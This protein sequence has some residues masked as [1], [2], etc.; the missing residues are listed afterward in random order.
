MGAQYCSPGAVQAECSSVLIVH[1]LDI[2]AADVQ[3]TLRGTG[4]FDIV[5]TFNAR[6]SNPEASQLA[7][8]HAVLVYNGGDRFNDPNL[9]G[10]RLAAYHNQGGGVVVA[11]AANTASF[12]SSLRGA[13]GAPANGYALL[14]YAPLKSISGHANN[15][16]SLGDVLEP[17]SPLLTDVTSLDA[18]S[19][20]RS[21]APVVS[22]RGIVVARWRGGGMEPLVVRGLRGARTLV[23]LNFFPPSRTLV[24]WAWSGSGAALM[25]N[26]LKFSRCMHLL[27]C[28]PGTFL[29][30]GEAPCTGPG[31]TI[32]NERL[33]DWCVGVVVWDGVIT[34]RAILPCM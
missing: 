17:Q 26:A 21:T 13:Y 32:S 31:E 23:E 11:F 33:L 12:S 18:P 15:P 7:A 34:G 10:D 22:C 9:L 19:A 24:P 27:G 29:A 2:S 16:D 14:D 25:R 30:A 3:A 1:D 5:D 6:T 20:Y 8:Y 28:W 4:A